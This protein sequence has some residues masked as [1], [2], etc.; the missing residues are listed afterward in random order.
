MKKFNYFFAIVLPCLFFNSWA[1]SLNHTENRS[2]YDHLFEVN[3]N[4]RDFKNVIPNQYLSFQTDVER[5]Q[6]HLDWVEKIL[7]NSENS[8][9]SV[10]QK[11]NR[12]NTLDI[13]H[14]YTLDGNFPINTGHAGR[15]PYFI[16]VYGTHCAVGFLVKETGFGHISKA[17]AEKQNFAY[18]KEIVSSEL[19]QWSVDFGFTLDELALIQPGYAPAYN[20]S[21]VGNGANGSVTCSNSF[22]NKLIV[23]GA[24]T[25]LDGLPCMNV[26]YYS[27]NQLSCYGNGI[28]GK[29]IGV[30]ENG[31]NG[32]TV[33]GKFESNGIIYPLAQFDGNTW[34]YIE[35]PNIPNASATCFVSTFN[36]PQITIAVN[37]PSIPSGQEIWMYFGSWTKLA[38]VP[39]V[40]YDMSF[41]YSYVF[42]G[43]FDSIQMI[44]QSSTNWVQAKNFVS[45]GSGNWLSATD[46]V[47]D[48]IYSILSQGNTLYLGGY[49][50]AGPN[51]TA[52]TR[53]VNGVAQPLLTNTTYYPSTSPLIVKDIANY[54]N[55]NLLIG[56]DLKIY[57]DFNTFGKNLFTYDLTNSALIPAADLDS[58]VHTIA[59]FE[60]NYYFGGDFIEESNFWNNGE[61]LNHLIYLDE[62]LG[63]TEETLD[64]QF[65]LSP[66]PSKGNLNISNI[67]E[68]TIKSIEI[69]DLQGKICH[70][71]KNTDLN[72]TYLKA[73]T[74]FVRI[75]TTSGATS[76]KKWVKE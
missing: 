45:Q 1:F 16:D 12:Q 23:G 53:I 25:E 18:V 27:N 20:Y 75:E 73:G 52:L 39:G 55:S 54:T 56:G 7:R 9:L 2:L 30:A 63:L 68:E 35:I 66:N 28:A 71:T 21:Q 5:I 76:T 72:L 47:P 60:N 15:Q 33:A 65:A 40:I 17:I 59:S 26:G 41:N 32:V 13:L 37:A 43:H 42:A 38:N 67:N 58:T 61:P 6:M 19:V 74:Y 36:G 46:W 51:G 31:A 14:Q 49:A 8:E 4:W 69:L 22:G 11:L 64:L 48:T 24:F 70:Q 62:P 3:E 10:E 50:G 44:S 57:T 34:T 29:V